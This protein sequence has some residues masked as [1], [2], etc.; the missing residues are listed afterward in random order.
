MLDTLQNFAEVSVAIMGFSGI[1]ST[2]YIRSE[3]TWTPRERDHL[4]SLLQTSA[5]VI[6]FSLLPQVLIPQFGE[7]YV[8]W[9]IANSLYLIV[10]FAHYVTI[11]RKMKRA[12]AA[13]KS[14]A[15]GRRNA[16]ASGVIATALICCQM[17][18]ILFGSIDQMHFVYLLILLWHTA[19]A[20]AMFCA[21][22]IR[23]TPTIKHQ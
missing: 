11:A 9:V 2:V 20:I 18:A 8:L 17:L 5:M 23:V 19:C 10:H 3:Q 15:I 14:Y 6:G 22:L 4:L 12:L 21:L 13:N 16:Y 7:G 1:V